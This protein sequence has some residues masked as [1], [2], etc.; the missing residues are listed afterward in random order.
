M[1]VSKK[2]IFSV[3]LV[4]C[5]LLQTYI[6]APLA[7]AEALDAAYV[8]N[9][10]QSIGYITLN[11]VNIEHSTTLTDNGNGTY[12]L[13]S[14]IMSKP[15]RQEVSNIVPGANGKIVLTAEKGVYSVVKDGWYLLDLWGGAGA[16]VEGAGSGGKGG[17]VYGKVYL[18]AGQTLY[19][20]LGSNGQATQ[21]AH[22]GGGAN[23]TGGGHGLVGSYTVGG[24]GGYS[25]VFL[26]NEGRFDALYSDFDFSKDDITEADRVTKFIM[27]AGGG[28][29]GGATPDSG[30]IAGKAAH[31]GD[32]GSIGGTSGTVSGDNV[33][34]GTYFSGSNGKSSGSS[35]SYVGKGASNVPGKVSD[36][37][38][39]ITDAE[40]VAPDTWFGT[41]DGNG[42]AGGSG[43]LRG[44]GGGAGYAGGSGGLMT[45]VLIASNVGG[46]GGGSSFF[47]S[48]VN[49]KNTEY[50]DIADAA[51][52]LT[53]S[54]P[55]STGGALGITYLDND[56]YS[57]LGDLTFENCFSPYT[58]PMAGGMTAVNSDSSEIDFS[59]E[60]H[61]DEVNHEKI[62]LKHVSLLDGERNLGGSVQIELTFTYSTGFMGGNNVPIFRHQDSSYKCPITIVANISGEQREVVV[63]LGEDCG[64]VNMP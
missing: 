29:G 28:G 46:G 57:F 61:H 26:Y 52:Y 13:A 8:P 41:V 12:T 10:A 37:M 53:E 32:G 44:G 49:G 59:W 22:T 14:T 17:H 1:S 39:G 15:T 48:T 64:S 40:A 51:A 6:Y 38:L 55:S 16:D 19:Y 60:P 25:A 56:D 63:E 45:S 54:N 3:L 43:E 33:I 58:I 47:V 34:A 50:A 31:G 35:T 36:S 7:S 2:R 20:T 62:S 11:G 5:I 42:G 4:I 23:G 18:T 27:I 9:S 24:G 21:K 30:A